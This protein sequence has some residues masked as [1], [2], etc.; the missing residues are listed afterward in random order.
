MLRKLKA[1]P[2]FFSIAAYSFATKNRA[3]R[4]MAKP[5]LDKDR[6]RSDEEDVT[7]LHVD[8]TS[9]VVSHYFFEV[10][11]IVDLHSII[12]YVYRFL[13][14]RH[15]LRRLSLDQKN[16]CFNKHFLYISPII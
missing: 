15:L 16:R 11:C 3:I 10:I 5:L 1:A 9:P 12:I 14:Y 4:I 2:I 13:L 6:H 7:P 8:I